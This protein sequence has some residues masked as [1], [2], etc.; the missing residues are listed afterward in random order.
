[1]R[2]LDE[3]GNVPAGFA[4]QGPCREDHGGKEFLYSGEILQ[5]KLYILTN[6]DA[7]RLSR[8]SVDAAKP[9]R[10]NWKEIIPQTD[11]VLQNVGVLGGK[12]F[13]QYEK[14][15]TSQLKIFELN[16]KLAGD[17]TLPAI[18]PFTAVGGKWDTTKPFLIPVVHGAAQHLSRELAD[19]V[20][21]SLWARVDAP[22]SIL[23][24]TR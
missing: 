2:R 17:I 7:P 3:D 13:A 11:A 6:E 4:G 1:M 5:G 15:A 20:E 12:L 18:G 22:A 14:N 10:E 21:T 16:G 23:R 9:G 24:L 8:F 19:S